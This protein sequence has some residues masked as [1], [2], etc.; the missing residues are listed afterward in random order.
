[1]SPNCADAREVFCDMRSGGWTLIG[2]LGGVNDN[3]YD[4]WLVA[5]VNTGLLRRP[6]I[7]NRTFGCID[8]V[9]LSVNYAHEV[10]RFM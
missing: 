5:N 2:Q 7:E 6:T 4:K 10:S 3:I 9:D 8:A 1:M